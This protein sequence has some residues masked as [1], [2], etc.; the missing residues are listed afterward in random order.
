M[1]MPYI[2]LGAGFFALSAVLVAAFE[3]LRGHK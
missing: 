2:A 1:D 3:K